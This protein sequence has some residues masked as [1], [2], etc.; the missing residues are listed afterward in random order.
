M[1][2]QVV[3]LFLVFITCSSSYFLG[4]RNGILL[5]MLTR[6]KTGS[7]Q[8]RCTDVLCCPEGS[9]CGIGTA[10]CYNTYGVLQ[11]LMKS[12]Q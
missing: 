9:I 7:A 4:H 2:F 5:D 6:P 3:F 12:C 11:Q 10:Y 8:T 1:Q